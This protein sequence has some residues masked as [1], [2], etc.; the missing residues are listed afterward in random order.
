MMLD[1]LIAER[2]LP[3]LGVV[4]GEASAFHWR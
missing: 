1:R 4:P 3:G 2:A